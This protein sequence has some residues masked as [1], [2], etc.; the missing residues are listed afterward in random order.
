VSV[1]TALR[2]EALPV[3]Y[4]DGDRLLVAVADPAGGPGA[5]AIA[6]KT[7]REAVPAIAPRHRLRALI[8]AAASRG[9]V[10]VAPSAA[11]AASAGSPA[12]APAVVEPAPGPPP[13]DDHR[14]VELERELADAR[15][16]LDAADERLA[17]ATHRILELEGDLERAAA[18][19]AAVRAAVVG[20]QPVAFS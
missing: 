6:R 17:A 2:S 9:P 3:A 10:P 16:R 4:L 12:G 11:S 18:T 20:E 8:E 14:V 15:G 1:D 13:V 5:G 19:I 7:G